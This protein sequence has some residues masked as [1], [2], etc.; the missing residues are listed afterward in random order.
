MI[1]AKKRRFMIILG[2]LLLF[3][4]IFVSGAEKYLYSGWHYSGDTFK[5][6]DIT[7]EVTSIGIPDVNNTNMSPNVASL[8]WDGGGVILPLYECE[9][10][11]HFHVCFE[12]TAYGYFNDTEDFHHYKLQFTISALVAELSINRNVTKTEI[13]KG[14]RTTITTII[15]NSD[16]RKA[17]NIVF[18][19]YYPVDKFYF[20]S[21]F[22]GC[23]LKTNKMTWEGELDKG[24]KHVCK[25]TVISRDAIRH[26][27][28]AK[29]TYFNGYEDASVEHKEVIDVVDTPLSVEIN[30]NTT[31]LKVGEKAKLYFTLNNTDNDE[32]VLVNYF[33]VRVPEVCTIDLR[34]IHPLQREY[35]LISKNFLEWRD[36][37]EPEEGINLSLIFTCKKPGS[38]TVEQDFHI[39][40][41]GSQEEFERSED[42]IV[43]IPE[44]YFVYS[45]TKKELDQGESAVI[46]STLI[47]PNSFS[48][49]DTEIRMNTSL[50][51]REEF[52][53][54]Y[55]LLESHA[56][57][58]FDDVSFIA[59]A[60]TEDTIYWFN[61]SAKYQYKKQWFESVR[62]EK[63][64]VKGNITKETT[65]TT[66][67]TTT[68][69]ETTVETTEE[70]KEVH[71]ESPKELNKVSSLGKA[72]VLIILDL[73]L[74][75]LI[76][77]FFKRVKEVFVKK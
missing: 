53:K 74:V 59:P 40:Y 70:V 3:S 43:R 69:E 47:N 11:N 41:K 39:V 54:N 38:Y 51:V 25:Y 35:T 58:E 65:T 29:A 73:V 36:T 37:L 71:V 21:D 1:M 42:I 4:A 16:E 63:I 68:T 15:N 75:L 76:I 23:V 2:V 57:I 5:V 13:F 22:E 46:K 20:Q 26:E 32:D 55:A 31:T 60:V 56:V 17:T 30:L 52:V 10:N 33:Q 50:P 27:S 44:P 62:N 48:Y 77:V 19:D 67:P 24:Y 9:N 34:E 61:L 8:D 7:F 12:D 28:T 45:I 66:V 49:K 72:I 6:G 18:E 14:E 64:L